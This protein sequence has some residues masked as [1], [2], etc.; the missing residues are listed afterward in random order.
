MSAR[1][2]VVSL[3]FLAV[4]CRAAELSQEAQHRA[5]PIRKVVTMLQDMKKQVSDEGVAEEKAFKE[6]MCYCKTGVSTLDQSI[7]ASQAKIDALDSSIKELSEKKVATE[8]ALKEHTA[9]RAEAKETMSKATALRDTERKAALKFRSDSDV[10]ISAIAAA[11]K[12]IENG[13]S[14]SFLQTSGANMLRQYAMEKATMSDSD[15]QA[16][17]SFLSGSSGYAPKSGQIVGILKE[18]SDEM[19]ATLSDAQKEEAEAQATYDQMMAAKTKE[20]NTLTAQIEEEMTRLGEVNVML[21]DDANDLEETKD[22]LEEDTQYLAELKKGCATKEAEWEAR[23]KVRADELVA[24]SETIEALNADDALELFKKTLPSASSSFV[25][26]QQGLATLRAQALRLL[27]SAPSRGPE[28][29]LVLLAMQGKTAGFEKVIKL[30]DEMMVNLKKEQADD[31]NKKLY[32]ETELDKSEDQKKELERGIEVSNTAI[33]DLKAAI[34]TWTQ[35]IADLKASIAALDKSVAEATKL[36]QEQNAEFKELMQNNKASKEI[37]L[38]AKNRLNK[39]YNPKLYK[40]ETPA[41]FVQIRAHRNADGVAPAPP[42]ETFDAYTKKGQE[43]G[44]VVSMLDKIINEI[45]M[46]TTEA[47]TE[48]KDAQADY[49][50]LMADAGTKRAADS[51]ALTEKSM[52]KAHGEES[53]QSE[54]ENKKDL[55]VQLMETTQV[56]SNLHAECDWLIKYFDVRKAA[57]TE[58]IESLDKAKAVLNGA[59]YSLL[60]QGKRVALRGA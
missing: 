42:P 18:M 12:A 38:W 44:V 58:E 7:A 21:S 27:R 17:L 37:L 26:V 28:I 52:A 14:G 33:D 57:R 22:T 39:F 11:V 36:R 48:E 30:I 23:C 41:A 31:D 54:E 47:E 1:M 40:E 25:Q 59:D 8:A 20:V 16:L 53:L 55:T 43:T 51:K 5:N 9:S 4:P 19:A 15:R 3:C 56:I 35:E 24:L 32:C 50:A 49:E 34:A 45:D 2:L 46:T 13:M 29:D 60:Q 10:N 6:F